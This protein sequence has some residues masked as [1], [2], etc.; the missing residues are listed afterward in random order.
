MFG[1]Q[2]D[3]VFIKDDG[4]ALVVVDHRKHPNTYICSGDFNRYSGTECDKLTISIYNLAAN[5]RGDIALGKYTT[6]IVQYG[7]KDEGDTLGDLFVGNIQRMI[8]Q[9]RDAVTNEL[10]LWVYDTGNFKSSQFFAGSYSRGVNY[11]AIAEEIGRNAKKSGNVDDIRLSEKLKEYAVYNSKTFFGSADSAMQTVAQDT[12][13]VYKKTSNSLLILTPEEIANQTGTIVFS[14]FNEISGKVESRSG[15]INIPQLTDTG[16]ELD[17]L[18]NTKIQIYN[19]LQINN[20]IV[21]IA[22]EGAIQESE[23]GAILDPDGLYVITA[24]SGRF[25]NDGQQNSMHITSV[26]RSVFVSMYKMNGES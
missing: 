16:L 11:Y 19:L 10:K 3:V 14:Q 17:C 7:Y 23:Y 26:A 13:M 5:I 22:Q 15:M 20:S 9:R 2:V 4:E 21:S 25:S 8:W 12:G 1:R 24:I 6:L 18:I